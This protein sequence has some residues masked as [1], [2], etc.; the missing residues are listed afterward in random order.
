[1]SPHTCPPAC[2]SSGPEYPRA[3]PGFGFSFGIFE[4]YYSS[5]A[6]FAGSGSIAA[7]GTTTSVSPRPAP[8]PRLAAVQV[9]APARPAHAYRAPGQGLLYLGTPFVLVLCRLRPCWARWLTPAGLTACALSLA[10]SSFC[11]SA[12]QLVGAQ[13]VLFGAG[14]CLAYCPCTLYIDEWFDRRKGLAYGIVRSAAGAAGVVLPLVLQALLDRL[15]FEST[16]RVWAGVLLACAPPLAL[17]VKP[18]LP[19]RGAR[20]TT[21]PFGGMRFAVSRRF[22]LY[23]AANVVEATGYFLPGIYL[24]TYARATAGTSAFLSALTLILINVTC[25]VGL[26]GMGFLSD[27]LQ[28]TTCMLL[29]AAGEAV[30]ILGIWGLSESLPALYVFCACYGLF[31]GS[32]AAIWP[33]IMKEVSQ[34]AESDGYGPTDPVMVQGHLCVGR[35]LGNVISGPLSDALIKGAPWRG[36]ARGGYGSGFGVL[37]LYTGLTAVISG[38]GFLC[39][40]L[41]IL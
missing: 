33:G 22:V 7:I 9:P 27:R 18:R 30:S 1:M 38:L 25:T 13:G 10:S 5:H 17:L 23:Q 12:P 26:V 31:A 32:W 4:D 16:M 29:S 20:T 41:G 6:P 34:R 24:P 35:G 40:I 39:R 28:V 2:L 14:G 15:G 3:R 19:H 11:T 8:R 36:K 37:I 21:Q